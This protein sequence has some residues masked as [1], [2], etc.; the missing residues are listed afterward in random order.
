MSSA[1]LAVQR[2]M[3]AALTG[4]AA[5]VSVV[6]GVFDGPPP[7]AAFPYL[8]IGDGLTADWST[9]TARGREVRA[10]VTVWD[11]G[12]TPARLHALMGHTE[13]ALTTLTGTHDGWR[14]VSAVFVRSLVARDPQGPWAGL[15]EVRVRTLEI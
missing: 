2:A 14:I 5:I 12:E 15:I 3:V 1:S 11:D 6:S 10:A 8:A 13:S 7:R 4:N 9:K